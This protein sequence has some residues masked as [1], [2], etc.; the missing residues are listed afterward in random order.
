MNYCGPYFIIIES[1]SS[2][3]FERLKVPQTGDD[4][5]PL[6]GDVSEMKS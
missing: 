5:L 3:Q 4:Q 6:P 1:D 2:T